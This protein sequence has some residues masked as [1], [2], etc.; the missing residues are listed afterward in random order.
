MR[1]GVREHELDS[2]KRLSIPI[3]VRQLEAVI[4]ISESLAKM[5]L[6][7]FAT[8]AHVDEALRLFQVSTL[9]A[10]MSGSLAGAEGFTSEEDHE[11]LVRIEKQ[12]K[13]RFAIGT[14]V[15]EASIV[16]DFTR[17]KYPERSVQKVIFTMIRRGELQHRMQRKLL[18][19][20][21]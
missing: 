8:D 7:P 19:R 5:Q 6:L 4:R 20:L 12:L 2:E 14:Q 9:D 15:S 1:F 13:R 16:Q 21:K 17:Q 18:Y 11:M 3:T 10:A